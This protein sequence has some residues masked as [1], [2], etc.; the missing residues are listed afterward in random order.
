MIEIDADPPCSSTTPEAL[1]SRLT[2]Q[3][4]K[5]QLPLFGSFGHDTSA[6]AVRSVNNTVL[7]ILGFIVTHFPSLVLKPACNFLRFGM[8]A[9]N[10]ENT[11][12]Y[13][14]FLRLEI[15]VLDGVLK[16]RLF[17]MR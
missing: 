4:L 10:H 16:D 5:P 13:A 9:L 1:K 8:T 7:F 12:Q 11:V 2:R 14:V 3:L 6:S 15:C 17:G